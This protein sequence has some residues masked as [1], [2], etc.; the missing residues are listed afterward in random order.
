MT[1]SQC[2]GLGSGERR[3]VVVTATHIF[4]RLLR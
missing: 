2:F 3:E 4:T 1:V